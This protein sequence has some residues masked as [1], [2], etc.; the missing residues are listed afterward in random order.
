MAKGNGSYMFYMAAA[1]DCVLPAHTAADRSLFIISALYGA[2][3]DEPHRKV[4]IIRTYLLERIL[5]S[6]FTPTTKPVNTL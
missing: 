2:A 5:K 4:R 1:C 6:G 3:A